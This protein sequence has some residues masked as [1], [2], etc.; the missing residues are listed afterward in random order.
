VISWPIPIP[1]SAGVLSLLADEAWS[2]A[3]A[4]Q[5]PKGPSV[6]GLGA[7]DARATLSSLEWIRHPALSRSCL[8]PRMFGALGFTGS[9]WPGLGA[10]FALP[11]WTIAFSRSFA[12]ISAAWIAGDE[13]EVLLEEYERIQQGLEHAILPP[14]RSEIRI[15]KTSPSP[16][17]WLD[18]V[19]DVRGLIALGRASKIVLA[20]QTE[21]HARSPIDATAVFSRLVGDPCSTRFLFRRGPSAFVG[22]TPELLVKKRGASIESEAL[23]GT[24]PIGDRQV[25]L[26][27]AK[28]RVEHAIVVRDIASKLRALGATVSPADR[29]CTRRLPTMVHLSTPIRGR[30]D[31]SLHVVDVARALHP[32]PAVAG[33]PTEEALRFLAERETFARGLY[34]GPVGWF[35]GRGD[36]ELHVA[37]RSGRIESDRAYAFAGAGIVAESDPECE[38]REVALK[39]RVFL[40]ALGVHR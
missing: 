1:E 29:P 36:G 20:R 14:D 15:A 13:P 28:I 37:I 12:Q 23:A 7:A 22:A 32:T 4:W 35:D 27:A 11:R 2:S 18:R 40:D 38:Y 31:R 21:L 39:E 33:S 6:I 8:A 19:R 34:A 16:E 26:H 24:A 25:D 9:G 10:G 5:P 17:E 3:V 30:L